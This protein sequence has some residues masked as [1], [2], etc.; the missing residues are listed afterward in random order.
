MGTEGSN[1][2]VSAITLKP[3]KISKLTALRGRL[4]D[5]LCDNL[6]A[7]CGGMDW[8][9]A[10]TAPCDSSQRFTEARSAYGL[11]GAMS[12]LKL[13]LVP[14]EWRAIINPWTPDAD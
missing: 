4:C 8:R 5:G 11:R 1:P 10:R 6:F 14:D 13:N 2:S 7:G 9:V 12:P 3:N